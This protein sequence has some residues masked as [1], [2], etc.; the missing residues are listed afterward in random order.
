[1]IHYYTGFVLKY[2]LFLHMPGMY[3]D[4]ICMY[5]S[6]P[7]WCACSISM[8]TLCKVWFYVCMFIAVSLQHVCMHAFVYVFIY[9]CLYLSVYLSIIFVYLLDCL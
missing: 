5:T 8:Y 4:G 7:V 1:M 2:L 3:A 6:V 9:V